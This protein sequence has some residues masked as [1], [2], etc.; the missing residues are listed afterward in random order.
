MDKKDEPGFVIF[1][2][3][4]EKIKWVYEKQCSGERYM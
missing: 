1:I 4:N 3:E 2:K